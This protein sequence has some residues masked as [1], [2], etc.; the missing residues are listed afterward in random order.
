MKKAVV[1]NDKMQ[2][3]YVYFRTEPAG[4]HFA[5]DFTPQL[6]PEQMA[7]LLPERKPVTDHQ[8]FL[9]RHAWRAFC[10]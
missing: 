7:S 1:V 10:S 9:A 3:G 2:R 5:P 8:V 4:K 6:T